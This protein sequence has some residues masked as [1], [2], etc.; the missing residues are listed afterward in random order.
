[1]KAFNA[2]LLRFRNATVNHL[3]K[4][5]MKTCQYLYPSRVSTGRGP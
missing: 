3:D 4:S 5:S 1:L 2:S